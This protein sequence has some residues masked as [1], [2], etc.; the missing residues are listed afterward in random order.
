MAKQTPIPTDG[1][2]E[3]LRAMWRIG[4]ARTSA[5]H[6]ALNVDRKARSLPPL[7]FNTT[8]TV[9]GKLDNKGLVRRFTREPTRHEFL[10]IFGED[11]VGRAMARDVIDRLF[12]GSLLSLVHFAVG[13]VK[14]SAQEIRELQRLIIDAGK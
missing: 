11:E 1:E 5:I 2:L 6:T 3:I 12:R 7:A 4:Q 9:L 13:A 14:P 10:A 8:A